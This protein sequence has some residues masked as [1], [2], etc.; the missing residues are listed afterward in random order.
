MA[1]GEQGGRAAGME[2]D[3]IVIRRPAAG[4][5]QRDQPGQ[6]LARIDR[7]EDQRFQPRAPSRIASI[8]AACGTP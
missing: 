1:I 3:D 6:S 8:V 2:E 4:P 7:I 5:D